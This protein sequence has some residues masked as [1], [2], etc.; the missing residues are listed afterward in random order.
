M[1]AQL[2][3]NE[4]EASPGRHGIGHHTALF[5]FAIGMVT[6]T[7]VKQ[8]QHIFQCFLIERHYKLNKKE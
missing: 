5:A 7:L 6:T 2:G 1:S 4:A 8:Q 3:L